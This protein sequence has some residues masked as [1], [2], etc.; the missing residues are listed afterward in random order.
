MLHSSDSQHQRKLLEFIDDVGDKPNVFDPNNNKNNNGITA[1]PIQADFEGTTNIFSKPEPLFSKPE[2]NINNNNKNPMSQNQPEKLRSDQFNVNNLAN[3]LSNGATVRIIGNTNSNAPDREKN[4]SIP[5]AIPN[6]FDDEIFNFINAKNGFSLDDVDKQVPSVDTI[7]NIHSNEM[8]AAHQNGA[9]NNR[10]NT[11]LSWRDRPKEVAKV[12][13]V[14]QWRQKN[15]DTAAV[16]LDLKKSPEMTQSTG[17]VPK[18]QPIPRITPMITESIIHNGAILTGAGMK[19]SPTYEMNNLYMKY[20]HLNPQ[21]VPN[22]LKP[23]PLQEIPTLSAL[24]LVK[25]PDLKEFFDKVNAKK[26]QEQRNA[27]R[28]SDMKKREF[29]NSMM[30]LPGNVDS[31]SGQARG[32][33]A[34]P[35]NHMPQRSSTSISLVG[36]PRSTGSNQQKTNNRKSPQTNQSG[37]NNKL[38]AR[39]QSN[40]SNGNNGRKGMHADK[41][42][43]VASKNNNMSFR[44]KNIFFLVLLLRKRVKNDAI[45]IFQDLKMKIVL[46][47]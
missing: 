13:P 10:P 21:K 28:L 19:P 7:K 8:A 11:T 47:R 24:N 26:S 31:A 29:S 14:E 30:S 45:L 35:A 23:T 25:K 36:F 43:K 37:A 6:V 1:D 18:V 3:V 32:K 27:N 16:A 38:N 42:P 44:E 4:T 17:A 46:Q 41:M 9:T 12:M 39:P 40:A 20:P 15:D 22:P 34:S 5:K 33:N 2:P